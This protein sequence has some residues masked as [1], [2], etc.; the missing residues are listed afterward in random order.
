[1]DVVLWF[2][3]VVHEVDVYFLFVVADIDEEAVSGS[4]GTDKV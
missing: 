1:V 3:I 2:G 4:Y